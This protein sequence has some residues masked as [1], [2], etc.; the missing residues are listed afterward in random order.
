MICQEWPFHPS[1]VKETHICEHF[2]RAC[3]LCRW[4]RLR[5]VYIP[6]GLDV[7]F[8]HRETCAMMCQE[9][10]FHPGEVEETQ[11]GD[12]FDWACIL[13]RRWRLRL[14]YT[15]AG[16][17]VDFTHRETLCHDVPYVAIS[18]RWGRKTTL[19]WSPDY[20]SE[21]EKARM[22]PGGIKQLN[23]MFPDFQIHRY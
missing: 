3:I 17:D 8:T 13:C 20:I 2:D 16:H 7:D 23:I 21:R 11:L 15:P 9:W 1:E 4:W 14:V 5:W 22:E 12:H 10:P 18:L 19:Q 6:A